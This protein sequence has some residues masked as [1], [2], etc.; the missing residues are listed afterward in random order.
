[1]SLPFEVPVTVAEYTEMYSVAQIREEC[2]AAVQRVR[3]QITKGQDQY[4]SVAAT[5]GMPWYVPACIHSLEAS[6]NFHT[7]LQNGDQLFNSDGKAVPTVHVPRG[8]GPFSPQTWVNAAIHALGGVGAHKGAPQ[9]VGYWLMWMESYNGFGYRNHGVPSPYLW[10][11]TDQYEKGH[12][13]ADG[14]WDANA[15]SKEPGAAALM[16]ALGIT[17]DAPF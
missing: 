14:V 3:S 11:F 17:S 1:M 13:V 10:G 8:I 9:T 7:Y 15:V 5:V 6:L 2:L 12:Y 16:K 4:K